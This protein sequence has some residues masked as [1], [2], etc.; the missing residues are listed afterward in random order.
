MK[1]LL[2]VILVL[3]LILSG[4]QK[5]LTLSTE[6]KDTSVPV[7][8]QP[9]PYSI[10]LR[11]LEQLEEMRRMAEY[12]DGEELSL[13]LRS[14]EGGGAHTREDLVDF[15]ELIDSLP[16]LKFFDGTVTFI[17]HETGN[18]IDTG[19]HY[20]V[21]YVTTEAE[22]GDWTRVEYL[23]SVDD[24]PVEIE[25]RK[26]EGEFSDSLFTNPIHIKDEN[27]TLYC[28]TREKHPSG[29]GDVIGWTLNVDRIYTR[30]VYYTNDV[31]SVKTQNVFDN[32]SIKS[33]SDM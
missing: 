25:K 22:N 9:P 13:Y 3:M 1:K 24:V 4:C 19:K 33:I 28:E 2:V 18:S 6:S 14:V 11:S 29:K 27:I 5:E 30:V 32:L 7:T 16:I 21:V 31:D 23:L 20:N 12:K 26:E 15:L 10:N 8:K 17:S